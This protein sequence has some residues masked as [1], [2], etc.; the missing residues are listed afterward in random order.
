MAVVAG[1]AALTLASSALPASAAT[2]NWVPTATRALTP[3]HARLL[4]AA[5]AATPLRLTV[6]LAMPDRPGL[7]SLIRAQQTP[8]NPQYHHYLTPAQFT[9]RFAPSAA[10]VDRVV[11]YLRSTGFTDVTVAS[12]RLQVTANGTVAQAQRAFNTKI[13]QVQQ[14]G[15]NELVNAAPAQVPAALA[16]TVSGVLGL[17]TLGGHVKPVAATQSATGHFPKDF[18]TIYNAG[19]TATGSATSIAIIAAGDLAPTVTDLRT[20]EAKQNLP[21]VPV[22]VIPTG[23]HST[24]TSAQL[25]WDLDSQ[26]STGMAQTVRQLS[27]YD[28]TSLSDSDL[29]RAFNAFAADDTAQAG[30][31]SLGE[32]DALA[33]ANGSQVV[34]DEAFA[35]AA[36]QG[37]SF[38]ASTGDTGASCAI[39]DT[40]GIPDSGPISTNYPSSSTYVTG[41]GGTTLLTDSTGHYQ[42]ET[43]W[44]AGGG[45]I[46]LTELPGFGQANADPVT[47]PNG[48]TTFSAGR[49]VP[50]IALDADSNTGALIYTGNTTTQVGGTSLSSPLALGAWARLESGH[51]NTLGFASPALYGLY[52]KANSSP[53]SHNATPG[54]HDIVA[55][56]NGLFPATPGWDFTTGIGSFDLAT[57]N[58][59]LR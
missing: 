3:A 18:Q 51:G 14:S 11:Q 19:G 58:R 10:T 4:G 16:H 55:G 23:P 54:F 57:L 13:N 52:D 47:L 8:G 38:F 41:V 25:E 15:K 27:F 29:A 42:S 6:G 34:D 48:L 12:N 36:A 43:A 2:S 35:E 56:T 1:M 37:Q 30:S 7:D 32:C 26:T 44:V 53:S 20:A 9:A 31:A 40:N 50:D 49:G 22:N 5:P 59:Q 46:S 33:Y 24:D 17:S 28:A 45:G 21:Q 39:L